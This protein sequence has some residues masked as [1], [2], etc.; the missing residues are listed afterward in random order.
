MTRLYFAR[1]AHSVYTPE[2]RTRPLSEKGKRDAKIVTELLMK[3]NIDVVCS[4]P[5]QRAIETVEGIAHH[6]GQDIRMV[7]EMKERTLSGEPVDDFQ[8]AISKVW[9]DPAFSFEGG[10]SNATA[11]KRGVQ[12]IFNLLE[13]YN[14]KNVAVG[15]HG[16]IMVLIMN[17]FDESYDVNFWR[18]LEMPDIYCLTFEGRTLQNVRRVWTEQAG[19]L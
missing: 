6:I 17:H 12:G 8:Q 4:S 15:T 18:A 10:E 3:E 9:G 16:N 19:I 11:Q 14:G 1:H 2:E 7:E 13:E 5:Y